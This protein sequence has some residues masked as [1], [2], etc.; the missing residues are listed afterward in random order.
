[1]RHFR[2]VELG[3]AQLP[4][5][6]FRGMNDGGGEAD[7]LR[8]HR[9][10]DQRPGIRI[11]GERDAQREAGHNLNSTCRHAVWRSRGEATHS[12]FS[13]SLAT[14]GPHLSCSAFMCLARSSGAPPRACAPRRARGSFMAVDFNASLVASLSRAMIAG[15]VPRGARIATQAPVLMAG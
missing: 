15:G 5:E 14:I 8:R 2:D 12:S 13:P 9:A 4:P 6:H 7:T 10:V 1:H 3:K 11:V